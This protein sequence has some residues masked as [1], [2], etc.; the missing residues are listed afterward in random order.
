MGVRPT[1]GTEQLRQ[2]ERLL[3]R[4]RARARLV[5]VARAVAVLLAWGAAW[6]LA[7]GLLDFLARL[8]GVP[9]LALL[10]IGIGL[11]GAWTVRVLRPAV[12]FRPS[13]SRIALRAERVAA[14]ARG[15]RSE[16]LLAAGLEFARDAGGDDEI[17]RDLRGS[18]TEASFKRLAST[19]K[20]AKLVR[21]GAVLSSLG[22]AAL[23]VGVLGA[24]VAADRQSASIAFERL[25]LP[26]GE[27]RWPSRT[28]VE[29]LM[30]AGVH[31]S[32]TALPLRAVLVEPDDPATRVT[33][34][35]R[36]RDEGGSFG[37]ER[38]VVLSAQRERAQSST[39]YMGLVYE[40]LLEPAAFGETGASAREIDI[41]FESI[42]DE[43]G[44]SRLRVVDPPRL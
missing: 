11:L 24:L 8:P 16:G 29:P 13:L 25:V 37:P 6:F 3:R 20:S 21:L 10:L 42:D 43:T 27:R 32:D 28:D 33:A 18:V 34:V 23:S 4:V 39:G 1:A 7:S 31:P 38:R 41:R 36:V 17:E 30:F 5:L 2:A 22:A 15:G 19:L 26:F 14:E 9:R 44:A 12:R 40:R 35:Y